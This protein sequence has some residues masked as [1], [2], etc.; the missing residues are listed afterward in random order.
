MYS[1]EK[2]KK[3]YDVELTTFSLVNQTLEIY[4][5]KTIDR[6][7]NPDDIFEGFPLWSKIW[8]ATAVLA[9]QLSLLKPDPSKR[10][11]EIGAGLGVA[12]IYASSMGHQ[13]TITEYNEDALNFAR[14]NALQNG[15]DDEMINFLDWNNPFPMGQFDYIIGSEVVFK[16]VDIMTLLKLFK[17]YLKPGG[18]II[19][20]EGM[21]KS[22]L[23]FVRVMETHY[24]L[25]LKKQNIKSDN[26][27]I[28]VVLIEMRAKQV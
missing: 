9:F 14:A 13:V 22:S 21:R 27:D 16:E 10:F 2:F 25:K 11:L 1:I 28:P 19:L 26:K 12:G 3:N 24:D 15:I 5:P 20:A 17:I 7:I 18:K 6:F 4:V 23:E 8:E